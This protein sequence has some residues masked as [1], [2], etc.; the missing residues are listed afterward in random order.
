MKF[1]L[2][3]LI[4]GASLI[5]LFTAEKEELHEVTDKTYEVTQQMRQKVSELAG[6]A[7]D[8]ANVV[9]EEKIAETPMPEP[10]KETPVEVAHKAAPSKA[11]P[12]VSEAPV[13]ELAPEVEK[14]R[15]EILNA[16]SQLVIEEAPNNS[17][18]RDH[19]LRLA[20]DLELY[21]IEA[22]TQ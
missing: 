16:E 22:I 2:F 4:V 10:A 9:A 8:Q 14:R 20:E 5:Y 12:K 7:S 15:N 19:L 13:A 21:S 1:I 3:N 6:K 11:A 18:R 17:T